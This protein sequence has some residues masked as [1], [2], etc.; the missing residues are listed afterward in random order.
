MIIGLTGTKASGK[1]VVA[2]ILKARDFEYSSLSDRV[3]EEA[4]ERKLS[5]YTVK[6]LQNIGNELRQKFGNSVLAK[7]TLEKLQNRSTDEIKNKKIVVDGIRNLG[8]IEEFKKTNDF[9]LIAVDAPQK[10]RFERIINRGRGSDPKNWEDFL[11][12]DERDLGAG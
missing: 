5:G 7:R 10:T 1:G 3:R 4:S 8:E 9:F 11:K 6:D 12:M 2:E